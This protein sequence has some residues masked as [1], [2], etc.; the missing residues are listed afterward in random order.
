MSASAAELAYHMARV[1]LTGD[2]FGQQLSFRLEAGDAAAEA[3]IVAALEQTGKPVRVSGSRQEGT[4]LLRLGPVEPDPVI[5]RRYHAHRHNT[6]RQADAPPLVPA[7][8]PD[9]TVVLVVAFD[10]LLRVSKATWREYARDYWLDMPAPLTGDY[11]DSPSVR[12][13]GIPSKALEGVAAVVA[14]GYATPNGFAV[15]VMR[16]AWEAA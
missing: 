4:I 11:P 14:L 1:A 6:A 9:D 13:D 8:A 3:D 12:A 2:A 16:T 7:D 10:R 15:P 5:A